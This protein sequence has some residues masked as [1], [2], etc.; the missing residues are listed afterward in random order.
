MAL[1]HTRMKNLS[2]G[3]RNT[4]RALA[5]RAGCKLIDYSI[6]EVFSY[7]GKEVSHVELLLQ[8]DA[9]A[10]IV[11]V[12]KLISEDRI[13][14]V[15]MLSE[16]AENAEKRKDARVY[17][18]W[19]FSLP[20]ELT[21]QQCIEFAR[22]YLQDQVCGLGM[23]VLAN[24]H[25]DIDEKTGERK[26]HCH[27]VCL[28]RRLEEDGLSLK[29]ETDWNRLTLAAELRESFVSYTNFHLAKH[30]FDVRID[31]RTYAEQGIDL[32]PQPKRGSNIISMTQK[33]P[34][35]L[36]KVRAFDLYETKNIYKILRNPNVIL[37]ILSSKQ[38]TFMWGDVQKEISSKVKD[39][40][41]FKFI[42]EVLRQS[43]ELVL[44]KE[45]DV[46]KSDRNV[47]TTQALLNKERQF[48]DL[49]HQ[50]EKEKVHGLS[51]NIIEEGISKADLE[52]KV[53]GRGGLNLEQRK[54]FEYLSSE[55]Q[56][57]TLIG[58]AGTGKTTVLRGIC[59]AFRQSD[60]EVIGL[61]PTHKAR[62]NL[63]QEGINS[64]TVHSFLKGYGEGRNQFSENTLMILDEAGMVDLK[65]FENLLS[66]VQELGIKLLVVG[67]DGQL[68]AVQ[69]GAPF[70][71]LKE[72]TE[73]T[74]LSQIIRQ[75]APWQKDATKLFGQGNTQ[76]ALESYVDHGHIKIEKQAL[77]SL[78][79][80]KESGD[81]ESL[82]SFYKTSKSLAGW[83]FHRMKIDLEVQGIEETH[84]HYF[85]HIRDHELYSFY[86]KWRVLRDGAASY[87]K[88]L[89]VDAS[90][91]NLGNIQGYDPRMQSKER[92]IQAWHLS[93]SLNK[94][95]SHLILAHTNR[96]IDDLNTLARQFLK[97]EGLLPQG[98][99]LT[100]E[101]VRERYDDFGKV[102]LEKKTQTFCVGDRVV[103][104]KNDRGLDVK[105]GLT[106]HITSLS[107]QNVKL[108]VEESSGLQR[109]VSFAPKLYPH[110]DLAWAMNIQKS[111]GQTVDRSFVLASTHMNRNLSY[112]A[113]TRH[114]KSVEVYAS[115]L[116]FEGIK[117]LKGALSRQ[118][119]KTAVQDYIVSKVQEQAGA[120]SK[121]LTRVRQEFDAV[122]L[123]G[124]NVFNHFFGSDTEE[125]DIKI[126]LEKSIF[127]GDRA[128]LLAEKS[129]R[130]KETIPEKPILES[131]VP[132]FDVL[133]KRMGDRLNQ[134]ILKGLK[135]FGRID[136]KAARELLINYEKSGIF[137]QAKPEV[138]EALS[139]NTKVLIG[140]AFETSRRLSSVAIEKTPETFFDLKE[141]V[142]ASN[143]RLI[144]TPLQR[145]ATFM[146]DPDNYKNIKHQGEDAYPQ[147]LNLAREREK[148]NPPLPPSKN[149]QI[150]TM[151]AQ[152]M[153]YKERLKTESHSQ[154]IR[155]LEA[156]LGR[157]Q[158]T[159]S[160]D[161]TLLKNIQNLGFKETSQKMARD[162][163]RHANLQQRHTIGPM[164]MDM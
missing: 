69:G 125:K 13:E 60:Y 25:M 28:T 55:G 43:S 35:S 5:Y 42:D 124:K 12:Q 41:L 32:N 146:H 104:F 26:P 21:D 164:K 99:D 115:A 8:K 90:A 68:Q 72:N 83:T 53:E 51:K 108:L 23:A 154:T 102:L 85:D 151:L 76:G 106:G 134:D 9:P 153:V 98:K 47:F 145:F 84:P 1:A 149:L 160:Q 103:L 48:L 24:F 10:W 89:D 82:S 122:G 63:Q 46:E 116:E 110:M 61:A 112:V 40:E 114:R 18:E 81:K 39:P 128:F 75:A 54:A 159:L 14:G 17:R 101:I 155:R 65:M 96:D 29:K 16:I 70:R 130:R 117:H 139:Q 158:D 140:K 137:D 79:H 127:E 4:V 152:H 64:M 147:L 67:D 119:D 3:S 56:L 121:S 157:I 88:L 105:N 73:S 142:I 20:R 62:E 138:F 143:L 92:L 129:A 78:E 34:I 31:G 87:L 144:E 57:K 97:K 150:L 50:L 19:E 95:D 91:L 2:R 45:R 71:I 111:Q 148:H 27:A 93:I 120:F 161:P 66:A 133:Q 49:C 107:S 77:P 11:N 131:L 58:Y 109:V 94:G 132:Y 136:Q 33:L 38:A 163:H 59:E 141:N 74:V 123:V 22:E 126:S 15:Q 135:D 37:E 113:M 86:H 52:L 44:L 100:L 6:G 36:D 162:V 30:G 118:N 7:V 156:G 80:L